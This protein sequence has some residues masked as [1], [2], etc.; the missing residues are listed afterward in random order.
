MTYLAALA[1]EGCSL[2]IGESRY[3]L[4]APCSV[5]GCKTGCGEC[6]EKKVVG[7]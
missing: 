4:F 7:I 1:V 3:A 5:F 6:I 2:R